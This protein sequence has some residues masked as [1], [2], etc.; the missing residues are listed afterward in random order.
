MSSEKTEAIVIRQADF[1]ETSRVVTFFTRDFGKL[2]V[3]AKGAKRLKG[4]F[5]AALDLLTRCRIVF[6]RKSSAALGLLTEAQA[7]QCFRPNRR[8]LTGLYAGYYVAEL[9]GSLT[10]EY[11]PHRDLYDETVHTLTRLMEEN[12][13]QRTIV[14]YELA[15]LQEIGHMPAL[16]ACIACDAPLSGPGPFAFWVSQGGLIC[17]TCQKQEYQRQPIHPGTLAVLRRI[18][19]GGE[20]AAGRLVISLEQLKEMR[21]ITTASISHILGRRPKL[22][23]YLQI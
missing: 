8:E 7:I 11:D 15:V 19:S 2:A 14:R 22:Y 4:P 23:R 18:A 13:P 10:E 17:P 21:Q 12:E 16:D 3:L 5:D 1:S 20:A 9:L 6:I